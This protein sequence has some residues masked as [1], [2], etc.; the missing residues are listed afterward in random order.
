MV[1]VW[2]SWFGR[3]VSSHGTYLLIPSIF[4][5]TSRHRIYQTLPSY[6]TDPGFPTDPT[7]SHAHKL[8]FSNLNAFLAQLTEA[9]WAEVPY[10]APQP[11]VLPNTISPID[12]STRAIWTMRQ[13]LEEEDDAGS[14]AEQHS[15][16]VEA[17]TAAVWAACEWF[18][19]ASDRLWAHVEAGLVYDG[20]EKGLHVESGMTYLSRG[21][22]GFERDRW[23]VWE[24]KLRELEGACVDEESKARLRGAL[25]NMR[26]VREG[27][28]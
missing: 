13:A 16:E 20:E 2:G 12:M 21:W 19:Y 24:E 25:A 22:R 9:A 15:T 17:S 23:D 10:P 4:L 27:V 26:R 6:C 18:V 3:Y 28:K 1:A 11:A 5:L 8:R 7:I 14:G